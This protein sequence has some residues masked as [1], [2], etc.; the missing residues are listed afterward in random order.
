[1]IIG[2]IDINFIRTRVRE[3]IIEVLVKK[4]AI[5][6]ELFLTVSP[7]CILSGIL[8]V[9]EEDLTLDQNFLVMI[10]GLNSSSKL[11]FILSLMSDFNCL[12]RDENLL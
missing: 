8:E 2:E 3:L 7:R 12:R 6:S 1:M 9:F 10:F 11:A 5:S 4:F